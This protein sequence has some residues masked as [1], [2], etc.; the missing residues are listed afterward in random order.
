[1]KTWL[2]VGL[3]TILG[4]GAGVGTA[5]FRV[6]WWPCE[7]AP[8]EG[9]ARQGDPRM[10]P[11]A[12]PGGPQP[13]VLVD[14]ETHNFGVMDNNALGIHDF[15]F[16]NAGDHPLTLEAGDTSCKCTLSKLADGKLAP[17]KSTSVRL[18]WNGRDFIGP[19]RQTATIFTNDP[20]KPRV[21]LTIQGRISAAVRL[22]PS[23][24]V[25]SRI[26]VGETASATVQVFGYLDEPLEIAGYELADPGEAEQFEVR[27]EP[28]STDQIREEIGAKSG[29]SVEI[30]AKSGLPLGAFRQKILLQTNLKDSPTV[31]IPVSGLVGSEISIVGPGWDEET[32]ILTLGSVKSREGIQRT[33]MIRVGGPHR[34][35][36]NFELIESVPDLLE[37]TPGE[38]R[39]LSNG[40][41]TL[42]RLTIQIPKG[43]RPAN[44]LGSEQGRFGRITLKTNHPEAPEL[45]ILVR[46]AVEG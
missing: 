1:M 27:F 45:R 4:V 32:G 17:G 28:L 19:F 29:Y 43:S 37:V 20:K 30:T 22:V 31:E 6:Q 40:R 12:A 35:E 25:F 2:A 5:V 7:D 13:K 8:L 41:V 36:V 24:L 10:S 34:K 46:F 39:E 3:A 42:T 26:S 16:T 18:E 23:E 21:T 38:P 9:A 33:L 44:H 15:I 11:P 14:Q